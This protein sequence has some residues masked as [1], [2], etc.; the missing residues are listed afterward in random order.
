MRNESKF[1]TKEVPKVSEKFSHSI[2]VN[3]NSIFYADDNA[4]VKMATCY[5]R[6]EKVFSANAFK[7]TTSYTIGA[8]SLPRSKATTAPAGVISNDVLKCNSVW[9]LEEGHRDDKVWI[10]VMAQKLFGGDDKIASLVIPLVWVPTNLIVKKWFPMKLK[11]RDWTDTIYCL[12]KIHRDTIGAERFKAPKGDLLV[13]PAWVIPS[14][15]EQ[16]VRQADPRIRAEDRDAIPAVVAPPP[17]PRR[18]RVVM[19]RE[20]YDQLMR[21]RQDEH[22]RHVREAERRKKMTPAERAIDDA[23]RIQEQNI[24]QNARQNAAAMQHMMHMAYAMGFPVPQYSAY[25]MPY[26]YAPQMQGQ[27][28]RVAPAQPYMQPVAP[29]QPYRYSQP[30]PQ[31]YRQP[32]PQQYRQP[33]MQPYAQPYMQPVAPVQASMMPVAPDPYMQ[34]VAPM[35]YQAAPMVNPKY[36]SK[37]QEK[38]PK[39]EKKKANKEKA[40]EKKHKEKKHKE[41]KPK[42]K[43]KSPYVMIPPSMGEPVY[44]VVPEFPYGPTPAPND[45]EFGFGF[46]PPP[47]V[48]GYQLP[49]YP[50]LDGDP[51]PSV[52]PVQQPWSPVATMTPPPLPK[53]SEPVLPVTPPMAMPMPEQAP[54]PEPAAEAEPEPT[55]EPALAPKPAPAPKRPAPAKPEPTD[56]VEAPLYGSEDSECDYYPPTRPMAVPML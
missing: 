29:A 3:T 47:P 27:P 51:Y 35:P 21:Q 40:K 14:D 36:V 19:D 49:A 20:H 56:D 8:G 23:R 6:V 46:A 25:Q 41:K 26:G 5:L 24:A 16:R 17:A 4:L 43:T 53:D 33:Y 28:Q 55:P 2:P 18:E 45:P 39:E 13:Q 38:E 44:P 1:Y 42:D 12:V 32:A 30:V 11:G 22:Q 15:L 34:P 31:Q 7:P 50:E 10:G 54:A 37:R 9:K 48:D 52:R